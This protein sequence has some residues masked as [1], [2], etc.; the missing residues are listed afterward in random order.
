MRKHFSFFFLLFICYQVSAQKEVFVRVYNAHF[1]KINKGTILAITDTSLQLKINKKNTISLSV[2]AIGT[3]K[4]K[5]ADG[6][7]ILT[8]AYLGVVPFAI[9]GFTEKEDSYAPRW[10]VGLVGL[11]PG[12]FVGGITTLFKNSKTFIINGDMVKWKVFEQ[13]ISQ[14]N[15]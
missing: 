13:H 2:N 3:I 1:K 8:G 9:I 15:K 7:N 10:S 14:G 4:T 5:R 6:H 11:I 12:A